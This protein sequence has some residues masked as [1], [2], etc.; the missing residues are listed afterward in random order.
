MWDASANALKSPPPHH[1]SRGHEYNRFI[2]TSQQYPRPQWIL[3]KVIYFKFKYKQYYDKFY[4]HIPNSE[5]LYS[6]V[7]FQVPDNSNRY[8]FLCLSRK[9]PRKPPKH[10]VPWMNMNSFLDQGLS[11]EFGVGGLSSMQ[12]LNLPPTSVREKDIATFPAIRAAERLVQ[13]ERIDLYIHQ[14]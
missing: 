12:S 1:L 11:E 2:E 10:I 3:P 8:T 6:R 13:G 4:L 9:P 5:R 7:F 14:D